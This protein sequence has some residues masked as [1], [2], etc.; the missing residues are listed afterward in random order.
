V[1]DTLAG[2][3]EKEG[4]DVVSTDCESALWGAIHS[5]QYFNSVVLY[6]VSN[7]NFAD[8]YR[9]LNGILRARPGSLSK[10]EVILLAD[11][12]VEKESL[13][14]LSKMVSDIIN[15]P[16]KVDR[17]VER[18]S[19]YK[20]YLLKLNKQRDSANIDENTDKFHELLSAMKSE[21]E[22]IK[23]ALSSSHNSSD[24]PK[25]E[26]SNML[27]NIEK[28]INKLDAYLS[29]KKLHNL[30]YT[31]I[32]PMVE[33]FFK[34]AGWTEINYRQVNNS[35]KIKVDHEYFEKALKDL[36]TKVM[37]I[38]GE[39]ENLSVV[40]ITQQSNLI[41]SFAIKGIDANSVQDLLQYKNF[42][43]C[44]KVIDSHAGELFI[45]HDEDSVYITIRLPIEIL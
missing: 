44:Q 37:Q 43:F 38:A 35:P 24:D 41:I 30:K 3:L 17:I 13:K 20:S 28:Q 16:V 18:I 42:D 8:C 15:L 32:K 26:R 6:H 7:D 25:N 40:E 27:Y 10:P 4:Y 14:L 33:K 11:D 5:N 45:K 36:T 1:H 22:R 31:L 9:S 34:E 12:S 19:K 23:D 39:I 29:D 21:L 2:V